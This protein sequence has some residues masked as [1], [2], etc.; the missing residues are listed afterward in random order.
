MHEIF[1]LH[2]CTQHC[3]DRVTK[4]IAAYENDVLYNGTEEAITD[5]Y[6]FIVIEYIQGGSLFD[7]IK[8]LG[9]RYTERTVR[10]VCCEDKGVSQL[11][12][13]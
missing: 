9:S 5:R 12:S 1:M 8:T 6:H 11:L 13:K 2:Y 4:L 3:P 7:Y 10:C